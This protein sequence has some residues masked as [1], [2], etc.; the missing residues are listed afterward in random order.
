MTKLPSAAV[1]VRLEAL[2]RWFVALTV[3]PDNA[4]AWASRTTPLIRPLWAFAGTPYRAAAS[5]AKVRNRLPGLT[6]ETLLH[7]AWAR[8]AIWSGL[9]T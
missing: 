1:A 6:I 2:V 3:A 8:S 9:V 4:P 7:E 5:T